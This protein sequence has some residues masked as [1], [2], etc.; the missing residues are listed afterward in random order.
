[1]MKRVGVA[2]DRLHGSFRQR[3]GGGEGGRGGVGVGVGGWGRVGD[4]QGEGLEDV[5]RVTRHEGLSEG[6]EGGG[7][8]IP[9]L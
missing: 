9:V 2:A 7:R 6:G 5:G 8:L 3:G 1:M 4:V